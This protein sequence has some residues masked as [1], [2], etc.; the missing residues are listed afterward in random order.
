[1]A[2]AKRTFFF[3]G[4]GKLAK[5]LEGL[6]SNETKAV[7]RGGTR[8]ALKP[9]QTQAKRDAPRN[10]GGLVKQ[11]KIRSLKRSR[12]KIGSRVT[13]ASVVGRSRYSFVVLGR[14]KVMKG[15]SRLLKFFG[16]R[17]EENF[18]KRAAKDRKKEAV[19]IF[20]SV[21]DKHIAKVIGKRK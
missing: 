19:S 17:K 2:K 1:M 21:V 8:E 7:I 4:T 14:R 5:K 18:L 9:I 13:I 16:I 3:V 11:I 12:R 15:F 20:A 6:T 10:T